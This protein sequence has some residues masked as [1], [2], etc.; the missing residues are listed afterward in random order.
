MTPDLDV[1]AQQWLSELREELP[2]AI[3]LRHRLHADP[4]LSGDECDTAA[5]VAQAI[6]I[7]FE[8]VAGCGG[9]ARIGP[10]E[11][12]AVA[13]RGELDALPGTERTGASFAA[14]EGAVHAC[15]HDVHL[16]ALTALARAAA[17]VNLPAG[18]VLL[19]Q[20]REEK[21][22]SGAE[23][24]ARAGVLTAQGVRVVVGAHVHHDVPRG[25]VAAGAGPVNAAS[26]ELHITVRGTGGHGAYPHRAADPVAALAQIALGLPEMVRRTVS[27]MDP[28]VISV[29][30]L[31]IGHGAANVLPSEGVLLATLRTMG[32]EDRR[33]VQEAVRVLVES[34]ARA[35]GVSGELTVV[36]GEPVLENDPDV[37]EASE[38]WLTE[39]GLGIAVPMRSLGSDDFSFYGEQAATL[40]SFVG[41]YERPGHGPS[42]PAGSPAP[43]PT[44]PGTGARWSTNAGGP[45]MPAP[46]PATRPG[47][48]NR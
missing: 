44:R 39:L 40:M 34:T 18:L 10:G 15:G 28:A 7:E 16:A 41:V 38:R 25:H 24:I 31:H 6:G 43:R 33:L 12:D 13:V 36:A 4:R 9:W 30:S 46:W 17:R 1:L 37:V 23:D 8:T 19:L 45:S 11:G 21:Y 32:R 35:Y 2:G 42:P 20:P 48:S 22:P 27:P 47:G 5:A 29:G 26:D 3:E 14:S